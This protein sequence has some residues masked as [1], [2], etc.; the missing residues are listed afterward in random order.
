MPL[1]PNQ[2]L[3]SGAVAW[4]YEKLNTGFSAAEQ[5]GE[6]SW[7]QAPTGN[8]NHTFAAQYTIAA[9]GTQTVD[10]LGPF[11]NLAV[12]SVTATQA[13]A[14]WLKVAGE[15]GVLQIEPHG[16]DGLSWPF[17]G[18]V[19]TLTP[20]ATGAGDCWA[21]GVTTSITSTSRQWLLTNT[22]GSSIVVTLVVFVS[23]YEYSLRFGYAHNSGYLAFL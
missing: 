2:A 16:T 21:D 3:I 10:L 20:G 5:D 15:G 13:S 19:E 18:G 23:S 8:Y 7:R 14:A 6:L 1:E 9:A 12:E 4:D 17:A 22:G 11:T